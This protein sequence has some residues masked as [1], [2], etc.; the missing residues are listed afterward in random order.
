VA[1]SWYENLILSGRVQKD[2]PAYGESVGQQKQSL[3]QKPEGNLTSGLEG[4]VQ[5]I[6][7]RSQGVQ[8]DIREADKRAKGAV[9]GAVREVDRRSKGAVGGAA[10]EADRRSGGAVE[11]LKRGAG[12]AAD[13]VERQGK[14]VLS[15]G[16]EA[17]ERAG[18]SF[19]ESSLPAPLTKAVASADTKG[20]VPTLPR[21]AIRGRSDAVQG[22]DQ[23]EIREVQ[24]KIP[25]HPRAPRVPLQL[26][27]PSLT[28]TKLSLGP[29]ARWRVQRCPPRG[30]RGGCLSPSRGQYRGR[31]VRV[32]V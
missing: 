18:A 17:L 1:R 22:K 12:E 2:K 8:G 7:S 6:D 16:R 21:S 13:R 24:A 5:N 32:R 10:R 28:L 4:V 15:S 14:D 23:K 19:Q 29:R 26:S 11:G 30:R 25:R 9:G 20:S 27:P 31:G 3:K